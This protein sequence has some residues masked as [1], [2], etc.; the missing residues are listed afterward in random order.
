[1]TFVSLIIYACI[2]LK[3]PALNLLKDMVNVPSKQL[4][5]KKEAN[6]DLPFLNELQ[7]NTFLFVSM[8][9]LPFICISPCEQVANW[10]VALDTAHSLRAESICLFNAGAQSLDLVHARQLFHH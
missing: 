1:M 3:K 9:Q 2:K 10:S 7:K 5:Y 4:K 8:T 6:A